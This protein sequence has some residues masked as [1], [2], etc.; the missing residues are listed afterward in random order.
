MGKVKSH[1]A[2]CKRFSVTANG[3]VK[4]NHTNRRHKLG[5]KTT[6]RKRDLRQRGYLSDSFAKTVK[7]LIPKD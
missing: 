6:K 1:R 4:L 5:K 7:S 3:K 2:S